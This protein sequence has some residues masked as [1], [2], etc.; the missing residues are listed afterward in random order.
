MIRL[1]LL[2]KASDVSGYLP[3]LDNGCTMRAIGGALLTQLTPEDL[4][5]LSRFD[6]S[7]EF[8]P[9]R[10]IFSREL[11]SHD[12]RCR[13]L[14]APDVYRHQGVAAWLVDF[15]AVS[16]RARDALNRL[17]PVRRPQPRFQD[18]PA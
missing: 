9:L 11:A 1:T 15:A 5:F 16:E 18:A 14:D 12:E 13:S 4:Q 3:A 17:G 7:P 8:A 10:S 2:T 6:A